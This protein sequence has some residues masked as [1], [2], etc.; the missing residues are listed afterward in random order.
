[1]NHYQKL[2]ILLGR[3]TATLVV[4][5]G[6]VGLFYG[7]ALR[8]YGGPDDGATVGALDQQLL[9]RRA[10]LGVILRGRTVGP[11]SRAPPRLSGFVAARTF[12]LFGTRHCVFD[13]GWF[14][15]ARAVWRIACLLVG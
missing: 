5:L 9:V 2:A 10:W 13:G 15:V 3:F 7:A 12:A 1:M 11:V 4:A 6:V 8:T 14:S